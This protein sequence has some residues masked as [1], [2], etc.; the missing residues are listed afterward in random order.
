MA[1]FP[2]IGRGGIWIKEGKKSKFLSWEATFQYNGHEV[3]ARGVAFKND[4]KEGN[5]PDYRIKV[6]DAFPAKP[7][8][9]QPTP[10][11]KDEDPDLPF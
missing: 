8:E 1:D 2:E 6:S 9:T 5:Q 11:A 10:A 3:T 7:R 4:H